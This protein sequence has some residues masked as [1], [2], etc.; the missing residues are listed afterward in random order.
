M[1]RYSIVV[2]VI[3]IFFV[4]AYENVKEI[5]T[6][7]IQK[8]IHQTSLEIENEI[9]LKQS[10]TMG[11][12]IATSYHKDM[13]E[14]FLHNT[15]LDLHILSRQ[16]RQ[17]T[18]YKN[19]HFKLFDRNG[20]VLY[21]TFKI[22][23]PHCEKL[24]KL[25]KPLQTDIIIDCYGIHFASFVPIKNSG[26]L[27]GY[28]ETQS[29]FNSIIKDLQRFGILSIVLLDKK[30]FDFATE[31]KK[32]IQKYKV[33]AKHPNKDFLQV[34]ANVDISHFIASQNP[35]EKDGMVIFRYP[36]KN[37]ENKTL[38]WIIYGK[39]KSQIVAN[40]VSNSIILRIA[41]VAF[42]LTL[43][44]VL[45][46]IIF[47]REK[48]R[49]QKRQLQYFYNILDKLQEIVI[50]NDGKN[51]KYANAVFFQYFNEYKN[52]QEFLQEHECICDFFVEEEGFISSVMHGKKWTEY[53]L[54]HK[55][56]PSY[57]KIH[58]K[59][60]EYIF[61]VKAN[62]IDEK[63]FVV[64]F[65]DVTNSFKKQQVLQE[66]AIRDPLTKVYNRYF[67][68]KSAAEKVQEVI[69]LGN[70]LL[71]AM[72][73]IDYF[74]SINDTYGHDKGDLVLREIAA[75][76]KQELRKSDSI[77]RVG[78]EEFLIIFATNDIQKVLDRLEYIRQKIAQHSFNEID[79]KVTISIGV[80]KYKKGE[81]VEDLYKRTDKALY[82][83]K[84]SGRNRLIYRGEND[85]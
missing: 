6:S 58:Y 12:G 3:I 14:F 33:V 29:Q 9:K 31:I 64:I 45:L 17:F 75:I 47:E 43:A 15:P 27:L 71:F 26:S 78:G 38:G 18:L 74:K 70:D 37:M 44:L 10:S 41:I 32:D 50:I 22:S 79:K 57:V 69:L 66:L 7:F 55:D 48:S 76:L 72:L 61:Q 2:V 54:E 4:L 11:L 34:L 82:Q 42:L 77:F 30:Y 59:N 35:L 62:R 46:T 16:L 49:Q 8:Y 28:L 52:L 56:R 53:L 81:S 85:A 83:A 63:D 13:K 19:I 67:F 65:I 36:I 68:E 80:A 73:D 84:E 21:A 40:Y 39:K 25:Q 20:N 1:R 51:M 5:E 23:S 60:R 24:D